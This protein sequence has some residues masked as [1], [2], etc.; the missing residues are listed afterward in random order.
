MGYIVRFLHW[1]CTTLLACRFVC[2]ARFGCVCYMVRYACQVWLF[3]RRHLEFCGLWW[4]CAYPPCG[5]IRLR[6]GLVSVRGGLVAGFCE[7]LMSQGGK[8]PKP[9]SG[10]G[11]DPTR[12]RVGKVCTYGRGVCV[13]GGAGGVWDGD[14]GELLSLAQQKG[15]L[16]RV[17]LEGGGG[18][19]GCVGR[20]YDV[21]TEQVCEG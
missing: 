12:R 7:L 18:S 8:W 1:A 14:G 5:G 17:E 21:R 16:V 3:W 11:R 6:T 15:C 9:L 4:W 10:G 2:F 19:R 20:A 13:L